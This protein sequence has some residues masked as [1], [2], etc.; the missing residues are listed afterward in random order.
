MHVTGSCVGKLFNGYVQD[1]QTHQ[2]QRR[3]GSG[4]E[5]FSKWSLCGEGVLQLHR[6]RKLS[7][8][9]YKKEWR[10]SGYMKCKEKIKHVIL[11]V[12]EKN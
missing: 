6:F 3:R 4:V 10:I 7:L 11:Q 2:L 1:K 5:L 8:I 9:Y 12:V